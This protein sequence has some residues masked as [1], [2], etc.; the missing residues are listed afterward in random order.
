MRKILMASLLVTGIAFSVSAQGFYFDIGLGMG[1]PTT[2]FDGTDSHNFITGS[3]I[4]ERGYDLGLKA[5]FGPLGKIPLYI[6]GEFAGAG[7]WFTAGYDSVQFNSFIMGPGVIFYPI[8][9]IQ[10]AGTVGYSFT[11]NQ[12]NAPGTPFGDGQDGLAWDVSVALD[13]GIGNHG[14]LFGVRYFGSSNTLEV[15]KA[16]QDS[17]L[18]SVFWKYAFRHIVD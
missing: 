5:G 2:K 8:P 4:K 16:I 1:W 18:I 7:H 10:L 11:A 13:L 12:S 15:S 9:L 6:V 14:F 17:S 3:G